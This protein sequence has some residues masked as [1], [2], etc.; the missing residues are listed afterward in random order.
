[1]TVTTNK[2]ES[3]T[4]LQKAIIALKEARAKIET[5]EKE[6]NEA[7]AIVGM[8]CRFPG[9][10]NTPEAFWELLRQGKDGIIPVPAQRWDMD[11]YY[12]EDPDVPNK[13]YARYGGFIEDVD[14]FD[15]SFFG[16]TPREAIAMD[17]QQ[18]LLL[19]VSWEA[20]ENA[21]I[22]PKKLTGTQTGV[23]VGI[24]LDDYAKRQVKHQVP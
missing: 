19:E 8:G 5:L 13:M 18:R 20:L 14:Q 7:I 1:M 21:G 11:S 22:A 23:F 2:S 4:P 16:I 3:L 17:P 24:G 10:A 6:K 9:G 15:A 12:D